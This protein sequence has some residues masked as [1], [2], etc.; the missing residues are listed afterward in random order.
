MA[1]EKQKSQAQKTAASRQ[2]KK[3]AASNKAS[4]VKKNNPIPAEPEFH[5]PVR[6]ISSTVCIGA[7]LVFLFMFLTPEDGSWLRLLR[8]FVQGIIGEVGFYV[9]IPALL[10]LFVIQAFSAGKPIKMRTICLISFVIICGSFSPYP[11]IA[12]SNAVYYS[13]KVII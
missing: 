3:T 4:K 12:P 11:C 13:W 9:S 6:L 1:Q 8:Y 10:Y 7:F 2:G 5:F